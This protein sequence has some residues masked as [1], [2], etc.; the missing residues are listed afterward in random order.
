MC[1]E[2]IRE[3]GEQIQALMDSGVIRAPPEKRIYG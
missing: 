1:E 2:K 3:A